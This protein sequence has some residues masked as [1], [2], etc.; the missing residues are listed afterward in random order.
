MC[1]NRERKVPAHF[2]LQPE[3]IIFAHRLEAS[4]ESIPY[5]LHYHSWVCVCVCALGLPK[6]VYFSGCYH[7]R[8]SGS[9]TLL[10][11]PAG[12][13]CVPTKSFRDY[14]RGSLGHCCRSSRPQICPSSHLIKK[15]EKKHENKQTKTPLQTRSNTKRK[16]CKTESRCLHYKQKAQ[17]HR[18]SRR[19]FPASAPV[20]QLHTAAHSCARAGCTKLQPPLAV[21]L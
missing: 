6:R 3:I 17:R 13:I 11:T 8:S 4:T 5:I 12:S 19:W 20:T 9:C 1:W 18:G 14:L 10:E 15:R 21:L 16:T 7:V 2:L